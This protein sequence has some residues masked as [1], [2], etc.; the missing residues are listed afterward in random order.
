MKIKIYRI[1]DH[2]GIKETRVR[3]ISEGYLQRAGH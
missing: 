1:A 3:S 2:S